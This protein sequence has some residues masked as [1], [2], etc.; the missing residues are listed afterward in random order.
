MGST[1]ADY[2]TTV[3]FTNDPYEPLSFIITVEP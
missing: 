3:L 2:S 1:S